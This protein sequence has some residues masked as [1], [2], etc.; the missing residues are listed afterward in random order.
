MAR[1]FHEK[2]V[3]T[4]MTQCVK[5]IRRNAPKC[6]TLMS[7]RGGVIRFDFVPGEGSYGDDFRR[8]LGM[9]LG[10]FRDM[11]SE[12]LQM[13]YRIF[14][15]WHFRIRCEDGDEHGW[16]DC[17]AYAEMKAASCAMRAMA[18]AGFDS[19]PLPDVGDNVFKC[20]DEWGYAEHKGA[21]VF[22]ITE[23][24]SPCEKVLGR[25]MSWCL[26]GRKR[27][28]RCWQSLRR[29][30]STISSLKTPRSRSCRLLATYLDIALCPDRIWSGRFRQ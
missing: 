14:P 13:V 7:R 16:V 18:R 30:L 3:H 12:S 23:K 26:A 25:F 9:P 29:L 17:A 5:E 21:I 8:W 6:P 10:E 28:T 27:R 24:D 22:I 11:D 1:Q 4:L 15:D 19:G 2:S 20:A